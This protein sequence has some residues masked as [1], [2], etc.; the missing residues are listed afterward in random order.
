MKTKLLIV[1]IVMLFS[2]SLGQ[3]YEYITKNNISYIKSGDDYAGERCN[4][5]VYYSPEFKDKPVVVWFHGG[6]LTG[7]EKFIPEQLKNDSLV[8]VAVNYRLLPKAGI[9]DCIDD[10]AVAVAWTFENIDKF[11][12]SPDKI[13]LAGHSAGG[14]LL[15]LIGLEKKWLE[16]YG[17]D[18]DSIA[19]LIPYSGQ[20]L[21]H[22][23][24]REQR[25]IPPLQPYID[26]Y[27]PLSHARKNAPPYIIISG[28]REEELFGRYEENA[29]MWRLMKLLGH[30][31]V[32]LYELEGY[33]HG[34]MAEPAHHILKRHIH[35][36][37]SGN[38]E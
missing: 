15:S 5:D 22:Y 38:K 23:A 11:G 19:G 35:K 31:Y 30:P 8:V 24:V 26:E 32:Y 13:F 34:D 7:G 25:G 28:D 16:K 37:L 29:Y 36:I 17:I 21:T 20:V 14:Y 3:S 10:A 1:V 27:S 2:V 4:L 18:A 6:G 12:G 33:N 9:D